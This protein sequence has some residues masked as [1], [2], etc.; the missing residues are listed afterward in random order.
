M[1]PQ[2]CYPRFRDK[3]TC[4]HGYALA[5]TKT[6]THSK[7]H[8]SGHTAIQSLCT[9]LT[10]SHAMSPSLGP[11]QSEEQQQSLLLPLAG[12]QDVLISD[13]AS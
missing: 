7:T 4:V 3:D 5:P 13:L 10:Q 12:K 11:G 2:S 1:D 9:H 8:I 6:L